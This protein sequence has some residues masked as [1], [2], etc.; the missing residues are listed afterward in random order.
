M[1][2]L[3]RLLCGSSVNVE[4]LLEEKENRVEFSWME[5]LE[6]KFGFSIEL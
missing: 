6:D 2:E 1:T 5:F 3:R 4:D